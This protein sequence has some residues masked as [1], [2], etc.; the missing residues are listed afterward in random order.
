MLMARRLVK[1]GCRYVTVTSAGRDMHGNAFGV[2]VS[3]SQMLATILHTVVDVP[4]LCLTTRI[5]A[6]VVRALTESQPIPQ[7]M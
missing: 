4:Q 7:L 3:S 6:D 5:P 1:A 2:D